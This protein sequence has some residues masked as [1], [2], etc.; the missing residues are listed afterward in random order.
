MSISKKYGRTYH[1]DYS[2]GTTS[3]DR[4]NKDW[5]EN[6]KNIAEIVN[7]EKMDGGNT[8]LKGIGIFARSHAAPTFQPWFN[9]MKAKF[10]MIQQDLKDTDIEIFGENM[11]AEH[12]II[13]PKLEEHFYVFA[14]RKHDMWLSWEEVKWYAEFFEYPVVPVIGMDYPK[15][16]IKESLKQEIILESAKPSV[17]GSMQYDKNKVL[18]P[19]SRE[20]IVTRNIEEYH[21]DDFKENVFKYVR[22]GHVTTTEHWQRNWKRATLKWETEAKNKK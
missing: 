16:H 2:P 1:Y 10:S 21:V 6:M 14:I 12:S 9:H 3:D 17:F 13:Y 8:C 11:F 18:E 7:T 4:I 15:A 19:C 5:W 20:G 22:K